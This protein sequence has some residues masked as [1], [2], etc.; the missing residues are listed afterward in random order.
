MKQ[1]SRKTRRLARFF[2]WYEQHNLQARGH[3]ALPIGVAALLAPPLDRGDREQSYF[4]NLECG[5][6]AVRQSPIAIFAAR[7]PRAVQSS[8][9]SSL[10]APAA[11]ACR[12]QHARDCATSDDDRAG[13]AIEDFESRNTPHRRET[14]LWS[15]DQGCC[16]MQHHCNTAQRD[17]PS[18]PT[19]HSPT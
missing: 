17:V 1:D 2:M 5:C 3:L 14:V 10:R 13:R 19:S 15:G 8:F 12:R 6:R 11:R 4:S 18:N 16:R 9:D 7:R